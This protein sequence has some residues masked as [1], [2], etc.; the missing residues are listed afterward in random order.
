MTLSDISIHSLKDI[1]ITQWVEAISVVDPEQY[2]KNILRFMEVLSWAR[3]SGEIH[4]VLKVNHSD[5]LLRTAES[6]GLRADVSSLNE[7]KQAIRAGFSP[8]RIS[9]NGPKNSAFLTHAM[10]IGAMIIVDSIEELEKIAMYA[11]TH[12]RIIPI[13]IRLWAFRAASD[14]RFGIAKW[15]WE[16]SLQI[17]QKHQKYLQVEGYHFHIDIPD[18][19]TRIAVFW[20][21]IEYFQK[22]IYIGY[23]PKIINIG[24]A[25]GTQYQND[26]VYKPGEKPRTSNKIYTN[27]RR[28]GAE[29]LEQLLLKEGNGRFPSIA[30]FIRENNITLW[31]EPGRSLYSDNVGFIATTVLGTR[32]DS[33]I[34][35]TNS[36]GL[37]M[38]E[39]ELPTNPILIND[40]PGPKE[41]AYWILGNL[42]LESDIIYSRNIAFWRPV[43]EQDILIFPNMAAY[44]MDFY[45]TESIGHPKKSRYFIKN[46]TL[47]PDIPL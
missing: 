20:E 36:F 39:E 4:T 13:M 30:E 46:G 15:L 47:I 10:E 8:D 40:G 29:F 3:I 6:L 21:S 45:E 11:E 43:L 37:W 34:L 2:K 19:D 32:E 18:I 33:L 28:A 9:V 25:Y 23:T 17:I 35:N 27:P 24:G 16:L 26:I 22:L 5:A 1:L 31:I 14:T 7:L 12:Q 41:N 38:R 42:C 44:H